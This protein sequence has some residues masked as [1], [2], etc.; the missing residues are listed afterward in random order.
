MLRTGLI[1]GL[2]GTLALAPFTRANEIDCAFPGAEYRRIFLKRPSPVDWDGPQ[3]A[4]MEDDWQRFFNMDS[5]FN[6][7]LGDKSSFLSRKEILYQA[8]LS[9]RPE[10]LIDL[11]KKAGARFSAQGNSA[12]TLEKIIALAARDLD[13][14]PYQAIRKSGSETFEAI[15]LG[16]K[17]PAGYE[18][19]SGIIP[20]HRW[21][22]F[23]SE[24]KMIFGGPKW[25]PTAGN[26]HLTI[27]HDL[28]HIAGFLAS[29]DEYLGSLIRNIERY[30]EVYQS[31]HPTPPA[32][33]NRIQEIFEAF[34]VVDPK[35]ARAWIEDTQKFYPD[36]THVRK[37]SDHLRKLSPAEIRERVSAF[38]TKAEKSIL[39]LGGANADIFTRTVAR[40]PHMRVAY[41]DDMVLDYLLRR[42]KRDSEKLISSG[43]KPTDQFLDTFSA[44]EYVFYQ[45]ANIPISA[46]V[47]ELMKPKIDLESVVA[48]AYCGKG[49]EFLYIPAI[50]R[51]CK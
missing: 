26:I 14:L 47:D 38:I 46:W 17:I 49:L 2:I 11:Y 28:G 23:L 19:Y 18:A 4:K 15:P 27:E 5:G 25:E 21:F 24:R 48:R 22:K 43:E 35:V 44:A 30:P 6:Q 32:L 13:L 7:V 51:I 29:R 12:P 50:N 9:G 45:R 31:G 33:T 41:E 8:S 1:I 10:P 34:E 40:A 36:L 16:S 3:L 42:V 39:S 37:M 20:A